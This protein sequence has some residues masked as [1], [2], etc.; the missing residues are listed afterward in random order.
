VNS[1]SCTR[2]SRALCDGA[3][4][5]ITVELTGNRQVASSELFAVMRVLQDPDLSLA[6]V[7]RD[8]SALL[9][10]YHDRGYLTAKVAEPVLQWSPDSRVMHIAVAID[11]GAHY[12]IKKIEVHEDVSPRRDEL[13]GSGEAIHR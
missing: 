1:S 7:D 10:A 8:L 9:S 3:P 2:T 6:V 5:A 12:R 11:E 13:R 4:C